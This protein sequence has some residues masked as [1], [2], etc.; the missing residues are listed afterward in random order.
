MILY[1]VLVLYAT[2]KRRIGIA[3][4]TSLNWNWLNF[5][6]IL[7]YVDST[8]NEVLHLL[9][10]SLLE[11][12]TFCAMVNNADSQ[13]KIQHINALHAIVFFSTPYKHQNTSSFL[14]FSGG[15]ER[16]QWHEMA[17]SCFFTYN[18]EHA[19]VW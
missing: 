7:L 5:G 17:E 10:K 15:I 18:F 12:F 14:I 13:H 16:E 6:M 19:F 3:V 8:K 11:N 2:F 4:T 9:K 1:I